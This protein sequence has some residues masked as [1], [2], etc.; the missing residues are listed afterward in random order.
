[1]PTITLE[2]SEQNEGTD[3]P[4]WLI[5]DPIQMMRPEHHWLA[6]MIDGPY[7]SRESAEE[8][9]AAHRYNF[10]KHAAVYCMSG[11]CSPEYKQA[12]RKARRE[13]QP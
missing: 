3:A 5:L 1:M 8:Y 12:I 2:V 7:F 6:H 4:F 11:H 13:Q 10:G 9:L